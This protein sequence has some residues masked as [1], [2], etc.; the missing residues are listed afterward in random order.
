M[1]VKVGLETSY[2]VVLSEFDNGHVHAVSGRGYASE[3]GTCFLKLSWEGLG[4]SSD[5]YIKYDHLYSLS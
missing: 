1:V 3:G 4:A 2:G 5:G